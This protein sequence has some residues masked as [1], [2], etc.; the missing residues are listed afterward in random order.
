MRSF[1]GDVVGEL[2]TGIFSVKTV[3]SEGL[4]IF[5]TENVSIEGVSTDPK[6]GKDA[7]LRG[8]LKG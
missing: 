2:S 1:D 3:L 4:D 8:D 5:A 7:S 6:P